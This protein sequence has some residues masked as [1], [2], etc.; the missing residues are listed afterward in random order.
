LYMP[1]RGKARGALQRVKEVM[2]GGKPS[3]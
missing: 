3:L 2:G 1:S